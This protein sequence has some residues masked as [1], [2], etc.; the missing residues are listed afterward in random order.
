M[1]MKC[2]DEELIQRY[3]DNE[4]SSEELAS[5]E[6]HL[7]ECSVCRE[8]VDEQ[9]KISEEVRCV[10]N[11]LC[12][13]VVDIEAP[14]FEMPPKNKRNRRAIFCW[15]I[16]AASAACLLFFVSL[17]FKQ[18]AEI[19]A[20]DEAIFYFHNAENEF[21]ANRSVMQQD[22]VIKIIDYNGETSEYIL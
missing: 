20:S 19:E 4:V 17:F 18:E 5:I 15:S 8:A 12:R 7:K 10:I 11:L 2:F 14:A 21:D 1:I 3:I 6:G 13:D 22:I 9:R 16:G